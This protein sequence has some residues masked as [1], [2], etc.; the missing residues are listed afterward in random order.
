MARPLL[1]RMLAEIIDN[2]WLWAV[3]ILVIAF[4]YGSWALVEATKMHTP[5]VSPKPP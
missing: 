5:G 2:L 1:D 3:V 4:I